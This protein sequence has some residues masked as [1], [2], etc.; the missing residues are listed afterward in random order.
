MHF[1]VVVPVITPILEGEIDYES[2]DVL[3]PHIIDEGADMLFM[4]G[5]T[6]EFEKLGQRQKIGIFEKTIDASKNEVPIL[7]GIN[8]PTLND[9]LNL[10]EEVCQ[11]N[12]EAVVLAPTYLSTVSPV[13]LL[14]RVLDQSTKPVILYNN[15]P[16]CGGRHYNWQDLGVLANHPML[17]GIKDSSGDAEYFSR[18]KTFEGDRFWVYQGSESTLLRDAPPY[19]NGVVAGTGNVAARLFKRLYTPECREEWPEVIEDLGKLKAEIRSLGEG[20]YVA[21]IKQK[22]HMMGILNSAEMAA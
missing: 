1:Q 7:A 14:D 20:N 9:T 17:L 6:G 5:L 22:L 11:L 19:S 2:L 16:L 18:L 13:T 8:G 4:S 3:I 15:P 10:L 21:G 12:L